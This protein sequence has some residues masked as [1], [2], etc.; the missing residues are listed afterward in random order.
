MKVLIGVTAS[1]LALYSLL[2]KPV[3]CKGSGGKTRGGAG[4]FSHGDNTFHASGEDQSSTN[5]KYTIFTDNNWKIYGPVL[6][7]IVLILCC[8]FYDKINQLLLRIRFERALEQAKS[9]ISANRDTVSKPDPVLDHV[10]MQYAASYHGNTSTCRCC[11]NFHTLRGYNSNP[12]IGD[13]KGYNPQLIVLGG[14]DGTCCKCC[15]PAREQSGNRRGDGENLD[16]P[17]FAECQTAGL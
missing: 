5:Y 1:N 15:G 14:G 9:G 7:C 12:H 8:L 17:C 10:L 6:I 13:N 11:D 2:C 4:S 3:H 16:P